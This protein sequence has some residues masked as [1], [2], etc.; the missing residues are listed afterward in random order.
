MK[1]IIIVLLTILLMWATKHSNSETINDINLDITVQGQGSTVVVFEAGFGMSKDTWEPIAGEV[2]RF[3][4]TVT[5]SRAGIGQSQSHAEDA[6]INMHVNDLHDIIKNVAK[7]KPVVL[8]GHSYGGM[9][10]TVFAQRYPVLVKGLVLID[11]A[12]LAQRQQLKMLDAQ[13]VARD[14]QWLRTVMPPQ[15]VSQYNVLVAQMD[16]ADARVH[17]IDNSIPVV[18]FTATSAA[19][20]PMVLE[21]TAAGKVL[22]L[23]LHNAL[24]RNVVKGA[25]F[26]VGDSGHFIYREHPEMVI[27]AISDVVLDVY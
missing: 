12:V 5:Y 17:P 22:W 2:S 23:S 6:T 19:P 14:D 24:M 20:D 21:E 13:R 3:A 15:L 4:T 1:K 25:H 10:S 16:K 8:V 18:L 27:Q 26:L 11:P 7:G 9:L